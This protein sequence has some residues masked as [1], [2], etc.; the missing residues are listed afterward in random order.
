MGEEEE[1]ERRETGPR[2]ADRPSSAVASYHPPPQSSRTGGALPCPGSH[3]ST[4]TSPEDPE[5]MT[6]IDS[7][8]ER[9]IH[10]KIDDPLQFEKVLH[11]LGAGQGNLNISVIFFFFLHLLL[12]I[13]LL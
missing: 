2:A 6:L 4:D 13:F 8:A 7:L 12:N 9:R 11:I 10:H 3:S 1:G 5:T